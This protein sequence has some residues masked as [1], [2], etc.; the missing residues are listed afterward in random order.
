MVRSRG[1]GDQGVKIIVPAVPQLVFLPSLLYYCIFGKPAEFLLFKVL[2]FAGR[3][4]LPLADSFSERAD[5]RAPGSDELQN[6]HL[7]L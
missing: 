2:S 6:R 4:E 7:E 5:Q 3:L 1:N